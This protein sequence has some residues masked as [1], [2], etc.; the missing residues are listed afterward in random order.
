MEELEKEH[1]TML[2]SKKDKL[3]EVQKEGETKDEDDNNK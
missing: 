2:D 3:A 1:K